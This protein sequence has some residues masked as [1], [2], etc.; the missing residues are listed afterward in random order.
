MAAVSAMMALPPSAALRRPAAGSHRPVSVNVVLQGRVAAF[1]QGGQRA[2]GATWR[3]SS[4]IAGGLALRFL[5]TRRRAY[6]GRGGYGRSSLSPEEIQQRSEAKRVRD[7]SMFWAQ[8]KRMASVGA[9]K[10]V[11]NYWSYEEKRLF[12]SSHVSK[13][14]NFDK[15]DSIEVETIGGQGHEQP[16]GSFTEVSEKYSLDEGLKANLVRCGYDK[17]TPVQKYSIPAAMEGTDVMC[18]AQTGSGKTAAFLVPLV[19]TILREGVKPPDE[20]PV[21]PTCVVLAPA[22]ELCQQITQEA[23]RVCFKT[24]ARAVAV[25]GGADVGQQ[26]RELSEGCDLL[27]ATPGRLEDFLSRG[28]VT[29]EKVKHLTLDEADRMLDMGFEPQ[30][31]KIVEEHGMPMPGQGEDGEAGRQ[32]TMFSATFPKEMQDMA[33]DFLDPGYM[34][35]AVGRVGTV[36]SNV[37]QHFVDATQEDKFDALVGALRGAKAEDGGIVKSLVFANTKAD[38]DDV[39][40]R[41]SDAGIR[42]A[43]IHGG[44]SQPQR[45]RALSDLRTGRAQALVATDVAARGLDLP[46]IGHVV[47]YDLPLN[48]EDYVH[49]IGR[50]GRIGNKGRATSMVGRNERALRDIVECLRGAAEGDEEASP[51]PEWME[52]QAFQ[53]QGRSQHRF[54]QRRG[55]GGDAPSPF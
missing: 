33:L 20:G 25:Y 38:V 34:W 30:I 41:L 50:T 16:I 53:S 47:N 18:T 40:R 43:P 23:K 8:R 5:A 11:G 54:G 26:L 36:N 31:R 37:D 9:P 15:Y 48:G 22:R 10:R 32:T 27:V 19:A 12:Q 17:P 2:T 21:A 4:G 52:E 29:M 51:V 3:L 45:D 28:L 44:L 24:E 39:T 14:I 49:R 6:G 1:A 55:R 13:G 7:D 35:I 46:G 42:A